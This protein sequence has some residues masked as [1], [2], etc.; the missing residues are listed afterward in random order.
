MGISQINIGSGKEY[1]IKQIANIVKKVTSFNGE[2]I[3]NT[4]KLDG[5]M[6]KILDSSRAR[7][8]GWNPEVNL[9]EGLEKVY[10]LYSKNN[11][12]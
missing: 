7:K 1:S 12:G 5:M 6:R 4:K 9:K 8:I 2:I 11:V 3:F 10:K